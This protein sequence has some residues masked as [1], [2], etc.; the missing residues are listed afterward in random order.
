[1]FPGHIQDRNLVDMDNLEGNPAVVGS[2]EDKNLVVEDI[3]V[4]NFQSV[5]DIPGDNFQPVEDIPEDNFQSVEDNLMLENKDNFLVEVHME[6]FHQE[7][8]HK[9]MD[10]VDT[11]YREV[12][13]MDCQMGTVN[14]N[15]VMDQMMD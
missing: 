1:M 7:E 6:T 8:D 9:L 4:N 13:R 10:F 3:P 5:E 14:K 2:L 15:L 11:Y 12:G